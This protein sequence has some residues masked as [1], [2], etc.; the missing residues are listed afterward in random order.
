MKTFAIMSHIDGGV[1]GTLRAE[2]RDDQ[3]AENLRQV[4]QGFLAL[5]RLQAQK[6]P[7]VTALLQSLQLSGSG[8]TVALSFAI[9]AEI[10]D[11]LPKVQ[12][13]AWGSDE[14]ASTS[15]P[16]TRCRRRRR[17]RLSPRRRR[18][19]TSNEAFGREPIG[20]PVGSLSVRTDL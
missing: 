17:P 18:S 1:T 5:G 16:G 4:V 3:A 9:P 10:F 14:S 2:A 11:M 15:S 8:K 19:P 12:A 20:S 13:P 7:N 6:D